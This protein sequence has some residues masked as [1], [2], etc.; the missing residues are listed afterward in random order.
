L[1][2]FP[3]NRRTL[4]S[5]WK[6]A[7]S[8]YYYKAK[9]NEDISLKEKIEEVLVQN[10]YY[11][12]RRIAMH[13]KLNKK[14]V[15]RVMQKYSLHCKLKRRIQKYPKSKDPFTANLV[16]GL[17]WATDYTYL[18]WRNS[19]VYFSTVIDVFT[20][21]LK[22][23]NL[24][25]RKDSFL[26]VETMNNTKEKP[27]ILHSDHGCEY[28]SS[29]YQN[30]L[31]K[32]KILISMSGKGHPWENGYQESFYSRFKEESG[33]IQECKNFPEI[34]EKIKSW[35]KY[36]NTKR[37]HTALKMPPKA[38]RELGDKHSSFRGT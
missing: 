30:T 31:R 5:R 4:L 26:V 20:R 18:K 27:E 24:S 8:T 11:G 9:P 22:A 25:T 17:V 12:H 34:R 19:F 28:V 10:P 23:W 16:K 1:K 36:Y 6:I 33:G 14:H 2:N 7:S 35:V 38:F 13:L 32:K 15:Q 21:E 29:H 3:L 37:I